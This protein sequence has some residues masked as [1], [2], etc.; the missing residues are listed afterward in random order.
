[1]TDTPGSGG[2]TVDVEVLRDRLVGR[3][4]ETGSYTVAPHEAWLTA[5]CIHAPPVADRA[6]HPVHVFLSSLVGV[7]Y[8]IGDLLDLAEVRPEDGPMLGETEVTQRRALRVGEPLTVTSTIAEVVRKR[9][10]SG[11][12]DLVT[13]EVALHDATSAPVGTVRNTYVYPRRG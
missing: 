6:L 9:G 1:V 2:G 13:V 7:G 10:R 5:D 4:L 11:V 12:F 8:A 3:E